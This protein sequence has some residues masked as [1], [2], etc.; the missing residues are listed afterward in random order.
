MS[1]LPPLIQKKHSTRILNSVPKT[2]EV[3]DITKALEGSLAPRPYLQVEVEPLIEYLVS[4]CVVVSSPALDPSYE[5]LLG[6]YTDDPKALI[7]CDEVIPWPLQVG[8]K[9][10]PESNTRELREKD[11]KAF[12]ENELLRTF[13]TYLLN[14]WVPFGFFLKETQERE[15]KVNRPDGIHTSQEYVHTEMERI[16]QEEAP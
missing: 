9:W 11:W 14:N 1:L 16:K 15:Y 5:D 7:R 3:L 12:Q 2:D 13:A 8:W 10:K 6:I 4:R